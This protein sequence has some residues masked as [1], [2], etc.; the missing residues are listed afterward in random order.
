MGTNKTTAQKLKTRKKNLKERISA[1][2][3]GEFHD[4]QNWFPERTTILAEGDSWF[5]YPPDWIIKGKPSNLV[6]HL[7]RMTK[8]GANFYCMAS[9]GDEA[10]DM[11]SGKQ[12]HELVDELRWHEDDP[13]R[14]Q[15]DLL[16][17]SGGGNDVVG[18]NDFERFIRPFQAGFTAEK[19]VRLDRL[20]RK[21]KQIAL[22]V[23]ELLDIRDH[24]S[25][26]TIVLTHT[27]D[28]PYPSNVG[29][30]FL[31]GLIKT[32]AW[33][34]RFMDAKGIPDKLQADIIKIFMDH[35]GDNLVALAQKRAGLIVVD[36]RQTLKGK[37]A[38]LN[39][40]HPTSEGFEKIAAK[41]YGVMQQHFPV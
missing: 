10:V 20:K 29:G 25:P 15:I 5:A 40:I 36:T 32:K 9:N 26:K 28:Y 4:M 23:E 33:M 21:T 19:C 37:K 27:Y 6:A 34:K 13:S 16:L 39:E 38:W 35:M 17:F 8:G 41:M 7:S 31:G 1:K 24:Y 2:S 3:V 18:K 14:T 22:A 11:V 30:V 12:K